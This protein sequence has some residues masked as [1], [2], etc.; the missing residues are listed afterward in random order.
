MWSVMRSNPHITV[1]GPGAMG[2]MHAG[3][4][5]RAGH[6]VSLLDYRPERAARFERHGFSV[7][8]AVG[9]VELRLP[10]TADASRLP[11]ADLAIVCVKAYST[12][13]ALRHASAVFSRDTVLLTL[14]NGLGNYELLVEAVGADRALAGTTSSGA[15]RTGEREVVVAAVGDIWIGGAPP[16][17][18]HAGQACE[19]FA[20]AGL[21]AEFCADVAA[22]LWRKA[23]VNAGINP[24]GA[25][26][27]VRNGVLLEAPALRRLLQGIIAEAQEIAAAE[28]VRLPEDMVAVVEEVAADTAQNDCS[29][30]QDLRADRRTEIRQINGALVAIGQRHKVPVDLNEA[31][32]TLV[33]AAERDG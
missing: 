5:A 8:G 4:L 33:I 21:S 10:C 1:I 27:G 9:D 22:M 29:M 11:A 30:L 26:A 18:E 2:L 7:H 6:D 16:A 12:A 20:G 15:C 19:I 25:L 14:Q 3:L 24:L 13:E 17:A 28:G 32:T 31:V 23:I